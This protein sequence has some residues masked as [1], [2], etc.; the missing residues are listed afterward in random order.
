MT[1]RHRERFDHDPEAS[2]YDNDVANEAHAIRAG[3][4]ALLDW[5]AERAEV[6]GAV[7]VLDLGAGTGNL[8]AR[9]A[10]AR[11]LV[12]VDTSARMLALARP[13]C[14]ER[15]AIVQDDL[16]GYFA[17]PRRFDRVVSTYAIHH[18]EDD[19][20]RGLFAAI[21]STLTSGGIAVF[22]D[23]MFESASAR[24]ESRRA[25]AARGEQDVVDAIDEE[26]F[27]LLDDAVPALLS[28][29]FRVETRRF[30]ELS[31]GVC[32]RLG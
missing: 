17:R 1:S 14:G 12:A 23:L 28:C 22:G 27:W 11:T 25:F 7:D 26:F 32:C 24:D 4:A 8:T 19:E 18:L 13:K 2:A 10:A 15:V 3:Y 16:L 31:W 21:R 9:L 20:K 6:D 30:S 29:G 5:V